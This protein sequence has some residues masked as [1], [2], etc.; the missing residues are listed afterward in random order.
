M[1]TITPELRQA[2]EEAGENP[3]RIVDPQT[4]TTYVLIRAEVY[5]H[6]RS[7]LEPGE[8][9]TPAEMAPLMWEVMKGDWDDPR[10]DAYDRYPEE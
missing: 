3:P 8:G 2:L 6:I 10:M 5:E 1:A 4:N 9:M 7:L